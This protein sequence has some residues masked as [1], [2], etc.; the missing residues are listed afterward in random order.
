MADRLRMGGLVWAAAAA[1][2]G[3]ACQPTSGGGVSD[4]G[5]GLQP[6]PA[7]IDGSVAGSDPDVGRGDEGD[8]GLAADA[9]LSDAE[10]PSDAEAPDA[11]AAPD[12][13]PDPPDA[14]PE[15]PDAAP[16]CEAVCPGICVDEICYPPDAEPR[17]P[18]VA[19]GPVPAALRLDPF[20]TQ[21][22]DVGGVPLVG[23]AQVP[24]A[25]FR[26]A[27]YVMAQMLAGHPCVREGLIRSQVR[28]GIM[29]AGEVTTDMP[30]HSDLYQAFPA[31]DWDQRAR[32]LGAT[33]VRPL[34]SVGAENLLRSA[35][36]RYAGES[37][38]VHEF[39]HS[40]FDIALVG[41]AQVGPAAFNELILAFQ[42]A[43]RAGLWAQTYAQTNANEYWAEG[44]QSWHDTNLQSVPPNGIHNHVNTREELVAH[45]PALAALIGRVMGDA[46]WPAWCD[47]EGGPPW[48][49]PLAEE[50]PED[51]A[52]THAH[53]ED[54]GCEDAAGLRSG[55]SREPVAL[56]FFNQ[57][58]A[59]RQ[60]LWRDRAGALQ[61]F[62]VVPGHGTM[63][64]NT[65]ET[66]VWVILDGQGRCQQVFS[67]TGA[68]A[69]A[70]LR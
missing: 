20:Y 23:S 24:E 55:S 4:D 31:T 5:G 38:L 58:L 17:C 10:G 28:I 33:L 6:P 49:D 52:F 8:F 13:T 42:A 2:L 69:R 57:S 16:D 3:S 60:V 29:A 56:E 36:D 1:L 40:W 59:P 11:S 62:G 63:R 50:A 18:V 27:Y 46:R 54:L 19:V 43:A 51:C 66:H 32:G 61:P 14:A 53:L 35:G 7:R 26:V 25:A 41:Q 64:M 21:H 44:V 22:V 65:F 34:T 47:L 9:D 70:L 30:E 68:Q 45:D 39:G 15:P 48:Q 67:A 37:I 12:A